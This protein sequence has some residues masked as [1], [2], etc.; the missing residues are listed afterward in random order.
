MPHRIVPTT[1]VEIMSMDPCP[2]FQPF[3]SKAHFHIILWLLKN[4][5]WW[6]LDGVIIL[7]QNICEGK[8]VREFYSLFFLKLSDVDSNKVTNAEQCMWMF[9]QLIWQEV[10][11]MRRK[12]HWVCISSSFSQLARL[13]VAVLKMELATKANSLYLVLSNSQEES[14]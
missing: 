6:T 14:Q 10:L 7:S 11:R 8:N 4:F 2:I 5:L 3:L 1:Q 13:L 12:T 9:I